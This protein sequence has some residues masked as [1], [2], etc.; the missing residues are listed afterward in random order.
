VIRD[1][2]QTEETYPQ[3]HGCTGTLRQMIAPSVA[4]RVEQLRKRHEQRG[5]RESLF[6]K[7][8][9]FV[10][11]GPEEEFDDEEDDDE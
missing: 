1:L 10:P 9:R 2:R 8:E 7:C 5:E 11:S 6:D 4:D 3:S